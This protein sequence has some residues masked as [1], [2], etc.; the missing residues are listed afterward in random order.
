[1]TIRIFNED[2][3]ADNPANINRAFDEYP[4]FP[5]L[6]RQFIQVRSGTDLET[7]VMDPGY[8]PFMKNEHKIRL[9]F[10][11]L[12]LRRDPDRIAFG[13]SIQMNFQAKQSW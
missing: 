8:D 3:A 4:G 11:I 10:E 9:G 13:S 1:M 7:K 6:V 12:F 2:I 5:R